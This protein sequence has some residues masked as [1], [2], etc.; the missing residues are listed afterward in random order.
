[1]GNTGGAGNIQ[2]PVSQP[3]TPG[4]QPQGT[5][6]NLLKQQHNTPDPYPQEVRTYPKVP[7]D[8]EFNILEYLFILFQRKYWLLASICIVVVA[9]L[10]MGI[11]KKP[12]FRSSTK[13][14]IL[15]TQ[16]KIDGFEYKK[17]PT[18]ASIGGHYE[19]LK[20]YGFLKYVKKRLNTNLTLNQISG[21]YQIAKQKA[22]NYIHINVVSEDRNKAFKMAHN[23]GF[24]YEEYDMKT[25]QK[26]FQKYENWVRNRLVEKER[27]LNFVERK[28]M[29][30]YKSNPT[31]Y[32]EGKSKVDDFEER[33]QNTSLSLLEVDANEAIL[34]NELKGLDSQIVQEITY[35][36]PL[37]KELLSLKLER[38]KRLSKYKEGH[39]NIIQLD[40]KI[41]S[42]QD[43]IKN[44]KTK[45]VQSTIMVQNPHYYSIKEKLQSLRS[46]KKILLTRK[47]VL[48]TPLTESY[49]K[50]ADAPEVEIQFSE[51]IRKK[52]SLEK[53]ILSLE[54]KLQETELNKTAV[55]Q[56]VFLMETPINGVKLAKAN[57]SFA[58][59]LCI[60]LAIGIFVCLVAEYIAPTVKK[61][62]DISK[63]YGLQM[64]GIIPTNPIEHRGQGAHKMDLANRDQEY[65]PY[66]RL[67]SNIFS[68]YDHN[69]P[70]SL[71]VTSALQGEGKTTTATYLAMTSALKGERV[72]IIDADLRRC[73]VHKFFGVE[74]NDGLSDYLEYDTDPDQLI[75][76]GPHPKLYV[77]SAGSSKTGLTL[78][79]SKNKF[80]KLLH[81]AQK[82]YDTVIIDSPPILR[83]SDTLMLGPLAGKT[84]VVFR[85][86]KT[87]LK[88]G[89]E[90]INQLNYIGAPIAGA[91]L[92]AVQ[93]TFFDKYYYSYYNYYNY[94]Y[95]S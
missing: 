45:A 52:S 60:G 63:N 92:N 76:Q 70:K 81:W 58:V 44:E 5:P 62:R 43:L 90:L 40:S 77:L 23:I 30:F 13:I 6:N 46:E 12:K 21:S 93:K 17:N 27:S 33:L 87:P 75:Q 51:L 47:K 7:G 56:E 8:E 9:G 35:D 26:K 73:G 32:K 61:G 72:L 91:V 65:E 20:S 2:H 34:E 50:F 38:V 95:Y 48:A 67:H 53:M 49:R 80:S 57:I 14:Q 31:F 66:R 86:D 3:H 22:S 36:N 4:H 79:S 39:P 16:K 74:N 88:A 78:S 84:L 89:I 82:N 59:L 55:P 18:G 94:E 28:I 29:T 71:L 64:L 85:S 83:V 15:G 11:E 68:A 42:I 41:S 24:L 1:M 54:S 10:I 25:K 19:S 69:T 37:E